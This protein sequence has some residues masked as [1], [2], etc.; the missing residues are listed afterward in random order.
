[1]QSVRISSWA[2]STSFRFRVWAQWLL[3]INQLINH[4]K[5]RTVEWMVTLLALCKVHNFV[6]WLARNSATTG[7]DITKF[8][9]LFREQLMDNSTRL[10]LIKLVNLK[11]NRW[12]NK[13]QQLLH[14]FI[15]RNAY[16]FDC[17]V[18]QG[19]FLVKAS[20]KFFFTA[21]SCTLLM[22]N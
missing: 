1:M 2:K 21:T 12:T 18:H 9:D 10:M 13:S 7:R 20:W 15:H 6:W 17:E 22:K 5:W 4:Q 3:F 11:T 8:A 19:L 14:A 16:M